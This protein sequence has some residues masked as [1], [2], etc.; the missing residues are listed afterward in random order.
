MITL[1]FIASDGSSQTISAQPGQSLMQAATNSDLAGI[2][3]DCGG[4]LS[5]ATCHVML[6]PVWGSLLPEPDADERAMLEFTASAS[7]AR[8]RLSCQIELTPALDGLVVHLP[9]SQH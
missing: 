4:T 1:H 3:A 5:C 9:A 8:S 6:D 7:E 2:D